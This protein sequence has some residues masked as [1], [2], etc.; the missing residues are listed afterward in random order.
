MLQMRIACVC[1][2]TA[3]LR[4]VSPTVYS[5]Y[6]DEGKCPKNLTVYLDILIRWIFLLKRYL[7][8]DVLLFPVE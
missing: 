6:L 8:L 2:H 7:H 3:H 5:L 1:T 4:V